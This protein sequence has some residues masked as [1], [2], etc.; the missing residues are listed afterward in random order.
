LFDKHE[1]VY[2]GRAPNRKNHNIRKLLL[3]HQDG[4]L[5][6]CTM[7]ATHYTWEITA[8]SAARE[9]EVLAQHFQ[10]HSRD[11]RCNRKAA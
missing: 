5:G 11:P 3:L 2:L 6:A 9:T 10:M 4:A 8:R 1:L 7:K